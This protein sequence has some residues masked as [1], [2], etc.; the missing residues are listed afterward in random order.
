MD[1]EKTMVKI[2]ETD[3]E[4]LYFKE[5]DR[6]L[7]VALREKSTRQAAEQKREVH[8]NHCFRCG[9]PSLAQV[10][11]GNIIIDVCVSERCG[12]VHLDPGE[13]EAIEKESKNLRKIRKAVL[14]IFK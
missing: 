2:Y 8:K 13:L 9:T 4:E 14:D 3:Q 7:I 12:A 6:Q 1:K 5:Q 10:K 11:Y